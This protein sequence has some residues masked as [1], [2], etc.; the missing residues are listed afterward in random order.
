MLLKHSITTGYSF[1]T[2][3]LFASV[4]LLSFLNI[5]LSNAM[6]LEGADSVQSGITKLIPIKT[7][8]GTFHIWTKRI[9][10]NPRIKVL[11]ITGRLVYHMITWNA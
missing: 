2:F 11:I 6:S 3:L 10:S 9:G 5:S 7:P 4:L 1:R 8:H